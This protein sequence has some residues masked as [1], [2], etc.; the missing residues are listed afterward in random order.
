[1]SAQA[2]YYQESFEIAMAEA[3]LWHLVEQMSAEQ[4]AAIGESLAGSAE[5]EGLAIHRPSSGDRIASMER[6]WRQRL[7]DERDRTAA[8]RL[9]AEKAVRSIL[10]VGKDIPISVTDGGEVY[11]CDG[12]TTRIA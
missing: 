11:R 3:G 12:R 7:E 2:K 6:E 10:R 8:A 9:G 5:N 1:M 4:R